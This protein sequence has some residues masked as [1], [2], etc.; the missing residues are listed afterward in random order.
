MQRPFVLPVQ[1]A[2]GKY[3]Y[4]V[5]RNEIVKVN[6]ELFDYIKK[7]LESDEPELVEAAEAIKEQ[8]ADLQECG[9][10]APKRVERIEHP[11]TSQVENYLTRGMGKLTLQVTQNCNLRCKYCIYSENSNLRQRSHSSNY[12]TVETAKKAIDFY[13]QHSKDVRLASI[14]FYGG[15]PLLAYP[16]IVEAVHYA[17]KVF[18]GKEILFAITTNATLLTEEIMDFLLDH[19]FIIVLS[20]DG[21][22]RVQNKNRVFGDGS[23]SYDI[24]MRNINDAYD[25]DVKKLS[26]TSINMVIDSTQRY[27]ELLTLFDE[28]A[29]KNVQ[30]NYYYVDKDGEMQ[31]PSTE[32]ITE[33]GY[34]KFRSFMGYFRSEKMEYRNKLMEQSVK[35]FDVD[36]G[37]FTSSVLQSIAAPSGPCTP[38][39]LR[40]LVNCYGDFYPCEKVNE[41][42]VM[43][44]GSLDTGFDFAKIRSILNVGQLD[45]EKCKSCWAISLCNICAR[46]ADD[47]E[48]LS[49]KRRDRACQ[50]SISSAYGKILE[51]ILTYENEKHL[52]EIMHWGGEGR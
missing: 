19:H 48:T 2:L 44:I 16:L 30:C 23:G 35:A 27:D 15:E 26:G 18:K 10:L 36:Q 28:P 21:P 41:N 52:R 37:R 11:A 50:E 9:Y 40:L 47:G 29:L 12:M 49:A 43:K 14:G 31:P 45:S 24:V 7:V 4:E 13:S 17:E 22:K 20:I 5:N 32:Y 38:G 1:T 46:V 51:K 42:E 6:E 25:R 3:F 33:L 8:F 39:K 34:D